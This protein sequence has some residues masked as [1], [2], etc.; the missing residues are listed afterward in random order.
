M[1]LLGI[2]IPPEDVQI[3]YVLHALPEPRKNFGSTSPLF[4]RY[5]SQQKSQEGM[6]PENNGEA[7]LKSCLETE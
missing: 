5:T 1:D 6:H 7:L 3:G 4:S 2:L